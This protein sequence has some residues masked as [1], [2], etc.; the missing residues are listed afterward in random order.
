[1]LIRA[2]G[3]EAGIKEYLETGQTKSRFYDRD[4]LDKRLVLDGDIN[5]MDSI[6]S[7]IDCDG[8]RYHHFT[9]SF[10]EDDISEE[11]LQ[12]INDEFKEFITQGYAD[13]EIYFYSE[14]HLPKIKSYMAKNGK[15]IERKP[16]I[17]AI[18]PRHNLLSGS[19]VEFKNTEVERYYD[20]FQEYINQKYALESPKD[21]A[22]DFSKHS[23]I[24]S[25]HKGD[26]F[27]GHNKDL[28]QKILQS[29]LEKDITSLG[30]FNDLLLNE[31]KAHVKYVTGKTQ[32]YFQIMLPGNQKNIRLKDYVFSD[33][34]IS[35]SEVDKTH[36]IME[37]SSA[38]IVYIDVGNKQEV[39][40]KNLDILAEWQLSGALIQ[41]HWNQFSKYDKSKFAKMKPHEK[42]E[43]LAQK[44]DKHYKK[45]EEQNVIIRSPDTG[46]YTRI[47]SKYLQGI[48]RN[49]EAASDDLGRACGTKISATTARERV[50]ES[51]RRNTQQV[52]EN[53]SGL[54]TDWSKPEFSNRTYKPR[55]NQTIIDKLEH[56]MHNDDWLIRNN[57]QLD[58]IKKNLN[59]TTVLEML[60]ITHGVIPEKFKVEI[61]SNGSDRVICGNRKYNVVDFLFKEI[62]LNWN[63]TKDMLSIAIKM[64]LD[65]DRERGY[66]PQAAKYLWTEYQEWFDEHKKT[67]ESDLKKYKTDYKVLKE[68]IR[69]WYAIESD[70]LAKK[71]EGYF[72]K[73]NQ[74]KQKLKAEKIIRENNLKNSRIIEYQKL[75]TELNLKMQDAYRDFL[76]QKAI[77]END[78]IALRELRRLRLD[79]DAYEKQGAIRRTEIYYEHRLS[80]KFMIDKNGLINYLEGDKIFIK[81]TGHRIDVVYSNEDNIGFIADLALKKYGKFVSLDGGEDFKKR[82]IEHCTN[83]NIEMKYKDKWSQKYLDEYKAQLAANQAVVMEAKMVEREQSSHVTTLNL[84]DVILADVITLHGDNY[85]GRVENLINVTLINKTTNKIIKLSGAYLKL[86]DKLPRGALIDLTIDFNTNED[87]TRLK[88]EVKDYNYLKTLNSSYSAPMEVMSIDDGKLKCNY[89]KNEQV[90]MTEAMAIGANEAV[91]GELTKLNLDASSVKS[92]YCG[93]VVDAGEAEKSGKSSYFVKLETTDGKQQ[94]LWDKK[95][96]AAITENMIVPGYKIALAK[97]YSKH[98]GQLIIVPIADELALNKNSVNTV[99]QIEVEQGDKFILPGDKISS[100]VTI[101]E[102]GLTRQVAKVIDSEQKV[103]LINQ[104]IDEDCKQA[105]EDLKQE[106]SADAKIYQI[107]G[108]YVNSGH[109]VDPF[110]KKESFYILLRT[111]DGKLKSIWGKELA[112]LVQQVKLEKSKQYVVSKVNGQSK[113]SISK[114]GINMNYRVQ[115]ITQQL[116]M[117]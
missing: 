15:L 108:K 7:N 59:A 11:N 95:L 9:L 49:I 35:L 53:R 86:L 31:F 61:G 70:K 89:L 29:I 62:N 79:F 33:E 57:K 73:I 116:T 16:H 52:Q 112:Q 109:G 1:M 37:V 13:N 78:D 2:N 63:E 32:N 106:I 114:V 12:K 96:D 100:R 88:L 98:A 110:Y 68:D 6:I 10:K 104:V 43:L 5:I 55:L 44:S 74:E 69:K 94:V 41:K 111:Q 84:K 30:K 105:A 20:A 21:N 4:Q 71:Y 17:H 67:V 65:V 81:D 48:T 102:S 64:Q 115:R 72:H 36:K 90:V 76:L 46:E 23:E 40:T 3:G 99:E 87:K 39:D 50:R 38:K 117:I 45:V 97:L 51:R 113:C 58:E 85:I 34:F 19:P 91:N 56:K 28:K 101:S 83:N 14:A 24:I 92:L 47:I 54:D 75:K 60:A 77:S 27:D 18:V 103:Q 25:R 82:F 66:D 42:L 8:E 107:A 22:R 26:I 80:I 93:K